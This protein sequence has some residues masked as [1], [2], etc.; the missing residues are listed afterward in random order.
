MSLYGCFFCLKDTEN[1]N[2]FT[3]L[4]LYVIH[5]ECISGTS[6]LLD[7]REFSLLDFEGKS[8]NI[9]LKGI[10]IAIKN[11]GY[12]QNFLKINGT[13]PNLEKSPKSIRIVC[14]DKMEV[15]GEESLTLVRNILNNINVTF[16]FSKFYN[17]RAF[18]FNV[19][20]TDI[21]FLNCSFYMDVKT[22]WLIPNNLAK[23]FIYLKFSNITIID[24]NYTG[25]Y[26]MT[27]EKYNF[28][29]SDQS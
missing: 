8:F 22:Q 29:T 12:F 14:I 10:V 3:L 28:F 1:A 23:S 7:R 25:D 26:V 24:S 6:I 4:N 18:E 19:L 15:F 2:S 13:V 17:V 16:E 20:S 9:N 5:F 21:I 11:I 27:Y